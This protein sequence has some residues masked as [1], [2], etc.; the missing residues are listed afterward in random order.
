[1]SGE[2]LKVEVWGKV[3]LGWHGVADV[4]GITKSKG[5][6]KEKEGE[7]EW[8]KGESDRPVWKVLEEWNINLANLV[9]LPEDV[10]SLQWLGNILLTHPGLIYVL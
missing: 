3:G 8:P 10:S 9:P 1:M 6:G 5:K 4:D 2:K 7:E